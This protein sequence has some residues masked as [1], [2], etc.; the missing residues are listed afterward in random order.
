MRHTDIRIKQSA[1]RGAMVFTLSLACA[2][3]S[4]ATNLTNSLTGFTGT[5]TMP[6]TQADV[7]AAGLNFTSI[8][9]FVEDPPGSGDLNDPTVQFDASGANFGSLNA[10]VRGRNYL[11]TIQTDYANVSFVAEVTWT[12]LDVSTQSAYFGLGSGEYGLFRIADWG[13]G[14]SAV[15]LFLEVDAFEPEIFTLTNDNTIG[16]FSDPV[17]APGLVTGV[18]RLRMTYDWFQKKATFAIDVAY[19]GGPF[20]ADVTT[21]AVSTSGLYGTDGWPIEPSRIYIGGDDGSTFKDLQITV[22]TPSMRLGDLNSDGNIT[23]ADWVLLRDNQLADLSG[24]THAEAYAMGDVTADLANNHDDFVLFKDLFDA[25]NGVGSF[26]AM[27]AG[28]PEPSSVV[29]VA[30]AGLVVRPFRHRAARRGASF[31]S[32][33]N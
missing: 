4:A 1:G 6:A 13:T 27:L 32:S 26:A 15:Q 3:A 22:S 18:N 10:D 14:F 20:V 25:A 21:P 7:A 23:P 28:V 31:P 8:L 24:K 5:S 19:A 12:T 29:L 9:G 16:V 33:A 2:V 30:L 11:R 17:E